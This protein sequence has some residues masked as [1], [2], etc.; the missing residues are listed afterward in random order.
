MA[1]KSIAIL[2]KMIDMYNGLKKCSKFKYDGWHVLYDGLKKCVNFIYADRYVLYDGPK[3]KT[4]CYYV[5]L[6]HLICKLCI[7][8][9][10]FSK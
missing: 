9:S 4:Q 3:S 2:S 10:L 1:Q 6:T 5:S 7:L 8:V